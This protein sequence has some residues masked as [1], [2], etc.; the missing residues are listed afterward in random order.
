MLVL[1]QTKHRRDNIMAPLNSAYRFCVAAAYVRK[2]TAPN[3]H[4]EHKLTQTQNPRRSA[5][6]ATREKSIISIA[7][8]LLCGALRERVACSVVLVGVREGLWRSS[9][10]FSGAPSLLCVWVFVPEFL[11][12]CAAS[13]PVPFRPPP[14]PLQLKFA[15]LLWEC[16][17][18]C[19]AVMYCRVVSYVLH[20]HVHTIDAYY[21]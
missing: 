5:R 18:G 17:G 13:T 15:S 9:A 16:C 14:P 11:S 19:S 7:L 8:P 4:T 2:N 3:A 21:I 1:A 12:P 6:R 10:I 20:S